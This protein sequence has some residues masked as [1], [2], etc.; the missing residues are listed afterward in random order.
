MEKFI[1]EIPTKVY[2]GEGQII[3]LKEEVKKYGTRLLLVYGGNS[4]KRNGIYES[5]TKLLD[6]AGVEL[7]ERVGCSLI[8]KLHLWNVESGHAES[9]TYRWYWR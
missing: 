6:E 8:P 7:W 2:F 4:I 1:Y 9:M 5:I 3:G